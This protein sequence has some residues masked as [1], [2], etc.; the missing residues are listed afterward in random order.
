MSPIAGAMQKFLRDFLQWR[1]ETTRRR[2]SA[3]LDAIPLGFCVF[4]QRQRLRACNTPYL[5]MYKL[6][7]EIVRRGCALDVLLGHRASMGTLDGDPTERRTALMALIAAGK[8]SSSEAH[9]PDGRTIKIARYPTPDGGWVSIHEDVS[10]QRRADQQRLATAEHDRRRVW[11]AEFIASFRSQAKASLETVAENAASTRLVAK[12]LLTHS[13]ETMFSAGTALEKSHKVLSAV[14]TVSSAA[15]ELVPSIADI[16]HQLV[17]TAEAVRKAIDEAEQTNVQIAD[18][19]DAGQKIGEVVKLIQHIASQTNLLALN[20]TIE[21][22]RAGAAGRGFG[23]VASEV[24]ALSV[25]TAKATEDIS[26]QIESVRTSAELAVGAIARIANRIREI[27]LFASAAV[28]SLQQQDSA[29]SE[30]SKNASDSEAG[31]NAVVAML[32][33]VTADALKT[34]SSA[35]NVLSA[36]NSVEAMTATLRDDVEDFLRKA[37]I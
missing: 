20:A 33:A 22:A 35:K 36:S 2:L 26:R 28:T 19:G 15:R 29:T 21:A 27:D 11:L 16:N 31:V 13:G 6:S 4:D 32:T 30:I 10:D 25:Q 5:A 17:R 7:P 24:K 37:A 1:S 3:G 8:P 34:S 18:L 14:S 23:V 12:E 9:L